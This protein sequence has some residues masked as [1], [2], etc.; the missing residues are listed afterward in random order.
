MSET[1]KTP[2][3]AL[4]QGQYGI[5]IKPEG[6]F[7]ITRQY[8]SPGGFSFTKINT[9]ASHLRTEHGTGTPFFNSILTIYDPTE[10]IEFR[11]FLEDAYKK[12]VRIN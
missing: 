10:D 4:Q 5:Q 12:Y 3:D 7:L 6:V 11:Q 2:K 1:R 8:E 9:T